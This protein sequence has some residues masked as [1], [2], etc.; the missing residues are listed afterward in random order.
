M[1]RQLWPGLSNALSSARRRKAAGIFRAVRQR[2]LVHRRPLHPIDGDRGHYDFPLFQPQAKLLH[3][4]KDGRSR[5]VDR[6]RSR[7]GAGLPEVAD[8]EFEIIRAPQPGLILYRKQNADASGIRKLPREFLHRY[9]PAFAPARPIVGFNP[10]AKRLPSVAF[11]NA[12]WTS[13]QREYESRSRLVLAV[14]Q[15]LEALS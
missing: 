2:E 4:R 1:V 10:A 11:T 5:I 14:N 6:G 13:A 8:L 9:M 7:F 12:Q 3:R 15:Q